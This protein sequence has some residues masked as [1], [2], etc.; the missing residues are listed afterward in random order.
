MNKETKYRLNSG[1]ASILSNEAV[2]I[3]TARSIS[4]ST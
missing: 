4:P 1:F 2:V 3:S